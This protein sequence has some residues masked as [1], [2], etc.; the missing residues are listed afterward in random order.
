MVLQIGNWG[1]NHE[2]TVSPWGKFPFHVMPQLFRFVI[3]FLAPTCLQMRMGA[4]FLE[5]T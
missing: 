1:S 5:D 3:F 2:L 4:G